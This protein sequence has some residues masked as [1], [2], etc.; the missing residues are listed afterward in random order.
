MTMFETETMADLLWQQ[1]H[2]DDAVALCGRLAAR[3]LGEERHRLVAK[4]KMWRGSSARALVEGRPPAD[5][6]APHR[7]RGQAAVS[8]ALAPEGLILTWSLPASSRPSLEA[9]MAELFVVRLKRPEGT[10]DVQRRTLP[11]G[12]LSGSL[13][14]PAADLH[15]ARAAVGFLE[16]NTFHPLARSALVKA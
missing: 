11:L 15:S 3:A 1:G 6:A 9:P 16:T 8:L 13:T 2:A 4:L 12:A 14:L 5:T 10:L 7:A